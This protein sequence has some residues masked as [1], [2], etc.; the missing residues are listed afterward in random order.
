LAASNGF[1]VAWFIIV[2]LINFGGAIFGIVRLVQYVR[3]KGLHISIATIALTL[4]IIGL[5]IGGLYWGIDPV[6]MRRI[7]DRRFAQAMVSFP[8]PLIFSADLLVILYWLEILTH[9]K[10]TPVHYLKRLRLPFYIFAAYLVL[11]EITC[12]VVRSFIVGGIATYIIL[13]DIII[14]L[15]VIDVSVFILI[16]H[17]RKSVRT[18]SVVNDRLK[19]MN[20]QMIVMAILAI[21]SILA[22]G[23][24]AFST[25]NPISNSVA[26]GIGSFFIVALTCSQINMFQRPSNRSGSHT[27]TTKNAKQTVSTGN[28]SSNVNDGSRHVNTHS[29]HTSSINTSSIPSTSEIPSVSISEHSKDSSEPSKDS[30]EPSK[31]ES[32]ESTQSKSSSDSSKVESSESA[33]ES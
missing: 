8:L 24:I 21:V 28:K 15:I 4:N 1:I 20:R 6:S 7:F 14:A 5:L 30:S 33:S 13:G 3:A 32:L 31:A 12:D 2:S 22:I 11:M 27:R 9:K 16:H 25:G 26:A 18:G 29:I 10:F 23:A 17:I 19:R